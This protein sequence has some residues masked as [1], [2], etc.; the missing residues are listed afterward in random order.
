MHTETKKV[1]SRIFVISAAVFFAAFILVMLWI[2]HRWG[3]NST[4]F[5]SNYLICLF[6]EPGAILASLLCWYADF[7]RRG[8]AEEFLRHMLSV[9]NNDYRILLIVQGISIIA[10]F[11]HPLAELFAYIILP[12]TAMATSLYVLT[13]QYRNVIYPG[14]E[15]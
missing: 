13:N 15:K 9:L 4:A 8:T 7:R 6:L 3:I 11:F 5:G 14:T 10:A 12:I 2:R 1:Y